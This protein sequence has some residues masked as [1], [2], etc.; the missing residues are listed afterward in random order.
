M[1]KLMKFVLVASLGLNGLAM[2]SEP[3]KVVGDVAKGKAVSAICVACHA[4]DGNSV[5]P[6]WPKIAGQGD[7]YMIK[8][9]NDFRSGSREEATMTPMAKAIASD[10]DVL[11]LAAYFSSQTTELGTANKDKVALGEA[12]YRGGNLATGVAAW[13]YRQW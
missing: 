13:A 7:A 9:L 1:K 4:A 2:A 8:Q 10:E 5:N 6:V 12:I 3:A 11:H